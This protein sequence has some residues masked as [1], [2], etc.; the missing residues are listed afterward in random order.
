MRRFALCL[1]LVV[2]F[3]AAV[4]SPA[5]A[6]SAVA[7]TQNYRTEGTSAGASFYASSEDG[8]RV[9][10]ISVSAYDSVIRNQ[11]PQLGTPE[12]ILF[13]SR[14]DYCTW[15]FGGAFAIVPIGPNDLKVGG[16]LGHATL[17]TTIEAMDWDTYVPFTLEIDL[18]WTATGPVTKSSMM[19]THSGG[20]YMSR[21]MSRGSERPAVAIGTIFDGAQELLG[22]AEGSGFLVDRT[23]GTL[24]IYQPPLR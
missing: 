7:R 14:N 1:T 5:S 21:D 8:C 24:N 10:Q 11:G 15:Q 3:F 6:A 4:Q 16:G 22:G 18:T 2:T 20:G 23:Q 13:I 17:R 12:V 19:A 9:T